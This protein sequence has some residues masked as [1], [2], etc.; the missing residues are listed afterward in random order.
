M[1]VKK[2]MYINFQQ[3]R[4]CRSVKTVLTNIFAQYGKLHTFATTNRN[5]EKKCIILDM[6]HHKTYMYI[7]FQQNWV[8][9]QVVTMLISLFAKNRK[10]HTF[11]TTN[12]FFLK[13]PRFQTCIIVER[14]CISIF[15]KIGLVDHSKPCT[16][17]YLQKIANCIFLQLAIRI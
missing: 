12:I 16:Q 3:N 2:Y 15:S 9:T 7:H 13:N 5:F 14:T 1:I 6:H 17:V 8:K 10:L 11:A 4:V